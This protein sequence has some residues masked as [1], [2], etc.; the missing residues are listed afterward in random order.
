MV[1]RVGLRG[2]LTEEI[3][4]D[5]LFQKSPSQNTPK[6]DSSETRPKT[7]PSPKSILAVLIESAELAV[8]ARSS[9]HSS[10]TYHGAL[11]QNQTHQSGSEGQRSCKSKLV[12]MRLCKSIV[13]DWQKFRVSSHQS[14]AALWRRSLPPRR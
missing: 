9:L 13:T 12:A 4:I 14:H 1:V 5:A 6:S 7:A 3:C 11:A 8:S 10:Q 2:T